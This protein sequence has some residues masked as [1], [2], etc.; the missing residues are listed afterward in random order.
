MT[1]NWVLEFC[2]RLENN[3]FV[4][5]TIIICQAINNENTRFVKRYV[6]NY[7]YN[8]QDDFIPFEDLTDQQIIDW[9][10]DTINQN[11][12]EAY[13]IEQCEI[14]QYEIDNPTYIDGNPQ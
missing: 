2:K 11:E 4:T 1:V 5:Q 6:S 14:M 8:G 12:V 10:L 3:G 9:L 13:C 7:E